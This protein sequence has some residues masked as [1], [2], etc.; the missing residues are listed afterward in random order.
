MIFWTVIECLPSFCAIWH[1]TFLHVVL[2]G[3][4]PSPMGQKRL[5]L[6]DSNVWMWLWFRVEA[7]VI[8]CDGIDLMVIECERNWRRR[9]AK[10][11]WWWQL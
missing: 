7:G 4:N 3:A 11:D 9:E 5:V 6:D 8:S 1:R 2:R 10:K